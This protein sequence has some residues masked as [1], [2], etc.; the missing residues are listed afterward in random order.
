MLRLDPETAGIPVL[1]YIKDDD[2]SA[3]GLSGV[4]PNPTTLPSVSF[5]V[6]TATEAQLELLPYAPR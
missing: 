4:D 2:V 5:R 3:L 1:S 6:S